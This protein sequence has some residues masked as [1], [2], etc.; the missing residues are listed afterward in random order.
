M[1][2]AELNVARLK[3]PFEDPRVADF[4]ANLDLVNGVAER[5]AGFVWRLVD[6]GGENAI[7]IRPFDDPAVITNLSV[8]DSAERLE[9]FVWNTVHKRFYARKTEWFAL[10]EKQH[11]V[12]WWVDEGHRPSLEEAMARLDHLRAHGDTDVAFGWSHLPHVKL[13]QQARCA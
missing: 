10:M 1:H 5:S 9:H 4:A 3:Y 6:D 8:W 12:M 13:W 7:D 2:L 11:F